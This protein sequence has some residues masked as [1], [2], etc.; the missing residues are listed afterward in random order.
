MVTQEYVSCKCVDIFISQ[1]SE[2]LD[3][4]NGLFSEQ[5]INAFQRPLLNNGLRKA[6]YRLI[7]LL[8]KTQIK[9]DY[10]ASAVILVRKRFCLP[11]KKS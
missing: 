5:A 8:E 6:N 10:F 2:I 9:K 3:S 7:E 11:Y 1:F 4:N